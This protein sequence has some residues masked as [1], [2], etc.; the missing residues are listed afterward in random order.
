REGAL[1]EPGARAVGRVRLGEGGVLAGVVDD[2]G[3]VAGQRLPRLDGVEPEAAEADG[4]EAAGVHVAAAAPPGP[5]VVHERLAL[6]VGE[7]RGAGGR[8][9][10][11]G[12]EVVN[13]PVVGAHLTRGKGGC[14]GWGRAG[15]TTRR[16]AVRR[17]PLPGF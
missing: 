7:A 2:G 8:V 16:P 11:V 17:R 6:G 3:V 13:R 15:G 9:E 4:G 14:S 10:D 1:E 5:R 12:A